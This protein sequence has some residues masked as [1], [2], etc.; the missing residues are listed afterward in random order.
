MA[1]T[2]L[3]SFKRIVD[4]ELDFRFDCDYSKPP[5]QLQMSDRKKLVRAIWLHFVFFFPHAEL[6]QLQKGLRKTLQLEGLISSYPKEVYSLL[7]PSNEFD[8][9]PD[10]LIDEF[11][12][13]ILRSRA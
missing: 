6:T 8:V 4:D 10:F 12:C 1:A 3:Y 13:Y 7:V 9:T 11:F 5:A 2:S